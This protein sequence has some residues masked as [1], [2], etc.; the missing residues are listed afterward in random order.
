M[1]ETLTCL[2]QAQAGPDTER[3]LDEETH[4]LA[5]DAWELARTHIFEEWQKATDPFNL[6]P[7]V[8]KAM[9]DAAE[10][11]RSYPPGDLPQQELENLIDAIEA[12][13]GPRIERSIREAMKSAD[14]AAQQAAA[15]AQVAKELGLTPSPPPQ[16]LPIIGLDDVHLV[17]WMAIVPTAAG[18]RAVSAAGT[19]GSSGA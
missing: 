9:R 1:S 14:D 17:C 18:A 8:P 15:V 12:P 6:Q 19:N 7:A 10:L 13:Y 3:V 16:P 5:Y 2:F 11:L 4:R